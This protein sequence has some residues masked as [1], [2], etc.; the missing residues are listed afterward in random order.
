M[1]MGITTLVAA[2]VGEAVRALACMEDAE[3][4]VIEAK[5]AHPLF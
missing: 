2:V 4:A 3:A 5:S 1:Q